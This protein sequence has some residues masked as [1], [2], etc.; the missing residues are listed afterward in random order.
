M[1][2]KFEL[3]KE[4]I[5]LNELGFRLWKYKYKILIPVFISLASCFGANLI[6]PLNI[7]AST[8][9]YP[10]NIYQDFNYGIYNKY[11]ILELREVDASFLNNYY[12]NSLISSD[13]IPETIKDLNILDK[14]EYKD[15]REFKRKASEIYKIKPGKS[16]ELP[17]RSFNIIEL[18]V[19]NKVVW[20]QFINTIHKKNT[21]FIQNSLKDNFIN[22]NIIR[23]KNLK[24]RLF[25]VNNKISTLKSFKSS[26]DSSE[27]DLSDLLIR[28]AEIEQ[29]ILDLELS[30]DLLKK[31][32]LFKEGFVATI[33]ETF[34][35][36]FEYPIFVI[37]IIIFILSFTIS[38]AFALKNNK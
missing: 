24:D 38:S 32:P 21:L 5:D 35:T 25:N 9:I 31:S 23:Q 36:K 8:R 26:N 13:I 29:S 30:M 1:I 19:K 4:E 28:K 7:K 33:L 15:E 37:Y 11:K 16:Q 3:G 17:F 6:K 22:E 2:Q 10:L 12:I 18:K 34:N 14:R 20:E 27:K